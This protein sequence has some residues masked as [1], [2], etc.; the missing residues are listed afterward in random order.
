MFRTY[1]LIAVIGVPLLVVGCSD[2]TPPPSAP[3]AEQLQAARRAPATTVVHYYFRGVTADASFSSSDP[4]GCIRTEV[5]VLGAEETSK[6]PGSK[7]VTQPRASIG[8]FQLNVCTDEVLLDGFGD[9]YD[10]T[11]RADRGQL[12][13]ARLQTT[14]LV[15]VYDAGRYT[16]VQMKVDVAWTGNVGLVSESSRY[17]FRFPRVWMESRRTKAVTRYAAVSGT[18]MVEGENLIP[19]EGY[20]GIS[21]TREGYL[22]VVH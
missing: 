7:A 3:N 1:Y 11:F 4:S 20:G 15:P 18:V 19:L 17:G 16:E 2:D 14:I 13:E 6:A 8:V 21:R 12:T 9:T 10:V 22:D 5:Y